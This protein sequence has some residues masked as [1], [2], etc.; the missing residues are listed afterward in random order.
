MSLEAFLPR[1]LLCLVK[2]FYYKCTVTAADKA[3]K[4]WFARNGEDCFFH[5]LLCWLF[6][7]VYA[8]LLYLSNAACARMDMLHKCHTDGESAS[9]LF[10]FCLFQKF[11]QLPVKVSSAVIDYDIIGKTLLLLLRHL[12][13]YPFES[14]LP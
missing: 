8:F 6:V 5:Y 11:F 13:I 14:L 9:A 3:V 1:S 2:S 10:M 7:F 12:A 4:T